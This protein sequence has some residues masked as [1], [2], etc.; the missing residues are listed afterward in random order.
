MDYISLKKEGKTK[1]V[2]TKDLIYSQETNI[3]V[4]QVCDTIIY[5]FIFPTSL[6]MRDESKELDSIGSNPFSPVFYFV[7]FICKYTPLHKCEPE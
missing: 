5:W 4:K 7:P 2:K 1:T 3:T 6:R